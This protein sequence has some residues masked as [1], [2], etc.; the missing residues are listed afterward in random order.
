MKLIF[1]LLFLLGFSFSYADEIVINKSGQKV[2]LKDDGTWVLVQPK[3]K[4]C[5]VVSIPNKL[6]PGSFTLE[7]IE[8]ILTNFI[9]YGKDSVFTIDF[10]SDFTS[11]ITLQGYNDLEII[12][13]SETEPKTHFFLHLYL[14][15]RLLNRKFNTLVKAVGWEESERD[16]EFTIHI[17]HSILGLDG[18][19]NF[20]LNTLNTFYNVGEIKKIEYDVGAY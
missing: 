9:L 15:K 16:S 5:S 14:S 3:D 11:D 12:P 17:D 20:I 6:S 18:V 2:L 8:T 13:Y 19:A 1:F 7:C 4:E 10:Y